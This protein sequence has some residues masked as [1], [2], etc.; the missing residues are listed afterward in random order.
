LKNLK[1]L[2]V[3]TQQLHEKDLSNARSSTED[4]KGEL[5][6]V[7]ELNIALEKEVSEWSGKLKNA[8]SQAESRMEQLIN[9]KV[10]KLNEDLVQT[11]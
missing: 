3:N 2:V 11:K 1:Q 4:L 6:T 8:L 7:K 9:M 10:A 5:Q